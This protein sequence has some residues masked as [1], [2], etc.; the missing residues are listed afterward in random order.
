[1]QVREVSSYSEISESSARPLIACQQI[2]PHTIRKGFR[3]MLNR[4]INLM[5]I[6]KYLYQLR[7]VDR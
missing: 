5:A 3:N 4:A 7:L 2:I 6:K 1:M